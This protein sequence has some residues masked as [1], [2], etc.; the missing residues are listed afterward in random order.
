MMYTFKKIYLQIFI[1][2]LSIKR[3]YQINIGDYVHYK[4]GIYVVL[5]GSRYNSWQLFDLN[6]NDGWV[7]R[8]D[9][10]KVWTYENMMYS[11]T[12]GYHFYMNNWYDIWIYGNI[13]EW[14]GYKIW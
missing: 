5:N 13:R 3:I 2:L 7:K 10:R 4:Y 8:K 12:S 14:F 11:F 9:C 1:I 6:N